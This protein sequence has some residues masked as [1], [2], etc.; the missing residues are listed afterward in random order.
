MPLIEPETLRNL[1]QACAGKSL[2]LLT[3][4]LPDPSGYG[5]VIRSG[6]SVGGTIEGIVEHKDAT[7]EQRRIQEI[8][9]GVMA[10]PTAQ[11]K[12]WLAA[13]KNDNAQREYYLTD[14]VAM[15]VADHVH[16]VAAHADDETEVL[17][18]NSPAQL[19]ELERRYQRRMRRCA[20]GRPACAWPTRR[21]ST[22]AA[23]WSAARTSRSTSAAC[24]RAASSSATTCASPRTA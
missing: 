20:D 24:S 22:C 9:T 17:G 19:A 7:P 16:V 11:L 23:S 13:L 2:A 21:A 1:V 15:A 12:R 18:I 8:Y 5:R 10:A 4:V 3:V 14:V 6:D